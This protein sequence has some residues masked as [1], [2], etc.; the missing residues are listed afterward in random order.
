M[1]ISTS[2]GSTEYV[3]GIGQKKNA[4]RSFG[5]ISEGRDPKEELGLPGKI[6]LE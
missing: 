2:M 5:R 4:Y 6:K 3:A 1:I